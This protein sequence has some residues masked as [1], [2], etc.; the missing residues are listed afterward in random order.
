MHLQKKTL[1]L[2]FLLSVVFAWFC[3]AVACSHSFQRDFAW[4]FFIFRLWGKILP[5]LQKA[6]RLLWTS[7]QIS[8][9]KL[10]YNGII[11]SLPQLDCCYP[12]LPS[13]ERT[14]SA[15][16]M[17]SFN[18]EDEIAQLEKRLGVKLPGV[19]ARYTYWSRS[20]RSVDVICHCNFLMTRVLN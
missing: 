8:L 11:K 20:I 1:F 17:D 7:T 6:D 3:V 18:S 13:Q 10:L 12:H 15:S 4:F 16:S 9:K 2:W 19:M 5:R 14:R